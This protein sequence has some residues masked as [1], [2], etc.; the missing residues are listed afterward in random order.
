MYHELIWVLPF[1][2]VLASI[3][4]LPLIQKH[5]WEKNFPLLCALLSLVVIVRYFLVL[6]DSAS[7]IHTAFEYISFIALIGSLYVVAGGIHINVK[8]ESTP[9]AN[10]LFLFIGAVF[11]NLI[12]T[13]GASMIFIRPWI[14][15]NKYRL[16]AYH[17]VFFIF[18][19]SNVGGGLTPIGD[20]PLFLGYLKGVPFFWVLKQ[21][22]PI[23]I[24]AITLLLILFYTVDVQNFKKAPAAIRQKETSKG[25]E[26]KFLG[27][28]NIFF[29]LMI[30]GSVF[31]HHPPFLREA[32]MILAAVLSYK[33]TSKSVH[34]SNDFNFG[35]I[36]EVA[37]LFLGIFTTM[38]PALAWLEK[39][40]NQL[41][42]NTPGQFYWASGMLSSVLDNAPTYLSFL[43]AQMGL[44]AGTTHFLL[45]THPIYIKAISV[46]S[47]FFGA[48]TYIGNGPNFLV[49]SIAEQYNAKTP[50]FMAYFFNY[51]LP[52]LIPIF[53]LIW[54]F[55]FR[56]AV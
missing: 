44:F 32:V 56:M 39:Y 28:H 10:C 8:G 14:R 31:I 12:G 13:T 11:A 37:I 47:V 38:I 7:L 41:G 45:E 6:K 52:I 16:T 20:P 4:I 54:F 22:W 26:W 17:I 24:L 25:E 18:I 34:E 33:T 1:I 36:K 21:V 27:A 49:K 30:V 51:S 43:S 19:I 40:A 50:S 9:V 23:W 53:A 46:G 2:A 42:V 15:M 5:W 35:P 48:V 55:F 29:L 3:A